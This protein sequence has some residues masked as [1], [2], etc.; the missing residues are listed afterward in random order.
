MTAVSL[1][2]RVL[3]WSAGKCVMLAGDRGVIHRDDVLAA[4]EPF[5]SFGADVRIP[6]NFDLLS[7]LARDSGGFVAHS[8]FHADVVVALL[9]FGMGGNALRRARWAFRQWS[10][11]GSPESISMLQSSLCSEAMLSLRLLL[12]LL[13]LTQSDSDSLW[14]LRSFLVKSEGPLV[15]Q[16]VDL[17]DL[18]LQ[19]EQVGEDRGGSA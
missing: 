10:D 3:S 7:L 2:S 18:K 9:G 5:V 13:R 12:L 15:N 1:V 6:V 16:S 17:R 19:L 14:Q 4:K 11:C 8:E